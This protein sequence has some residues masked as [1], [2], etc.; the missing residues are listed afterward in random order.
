[1]KTMKK[2]L[3]AVLAVVMLFGMIPVVGITLTSSASSVFATNGIVLEAEDCA[4]VFSA[5][6]WQKNVNH[7][8][9]TEGHGT[10]T[11]VQA[12]EDRG[13][14]V[15]F[16]L[17]VESAGE[18]EIYAVTKDANTRGIFDFSIDDKTIGTVD[19]YN[20]QSSGIFLEHKLGTA[21]LREGENILLATLNGRNSANTSNYG[22]AFDYFRLVS[23]E[24]K[25][26]YLET[27]TLDWTV[28]EGWS[29]ATKGHGAGVENHGTF[30]YI[31]TT[32][33]NGQSVT[34]SLPVEE[35]GNYV[36]YSM[37]KDGTNRAM[38]QFSVNG[39]AIGSPVDQYNAANGSFVEH[40]VGVATLKE[41]KNDLTITISGKNKDLTG[42]QLNGTFD[43]FRL[44]PTDETP[45]THVLFEC[46]S[47]TWTLTG[48]WN[49]KNQ[50]HGTGA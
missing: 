40:K 23:T 37:S 50:T 46:E 26:I 32:S 29:K 11:F 9:G 45:D 28:S 13:Q 19:F 15:G 16:S 47:V 3:C 10:F 14:T 6:W 1:M 18:Y 42:S 17:S 7:G 4:P 30:D 8:E 43:Y 33:V 34:Y 31:Y 41:G 27:E 49:Q 22:C 24:D 44:V 35:T 21:S 2:L 5:G 48:T 12:S 39:E 36:I 20:P 25:S 38:F